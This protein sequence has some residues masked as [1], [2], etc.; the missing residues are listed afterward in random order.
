[1]TE[2]GNGESNPIDD[3]ED[4]PEYFP[5]PMFIF[6]PQGTKAYEEG[7]FF[8][9]SRYSYPI[10]YPGIYDFNFEYSATDSTESPSIWDKIKAKWSN[11]K[12]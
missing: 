9:P 10:I 2:R 1:M 11:K 7:S 6:I 4:Y 12:V 5:K 8:I 3:P